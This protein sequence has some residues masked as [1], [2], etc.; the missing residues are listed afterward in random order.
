[1]STLQTRIR[2]PLCLDE[3]IRTV[4][5]AR[6]ALQTDAARVINIKVGRSGGYAASR[7]SPSAC[8]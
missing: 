8:A 1:M 3:C 7:P 4:D 6:K 2:T 5:H